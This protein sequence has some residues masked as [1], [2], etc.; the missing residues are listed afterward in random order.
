MKP[1]KFC[2]HEKSENFVRHCGTLT[3]CKNIHCDKPIHENMTT[4]SFILKKPDTTERTLQESH[5]LNVISPFEIWNELIALHQD[6][7]HLSCSDSSMKLKKLAWFYIS[8][9]LIL[10][11][12]VPNILAWFLSCSFCFSFNFLYSSLTS[13]LVTKLRKIWLPSD[14]YSNIR[15]H[16]INIFWWTTMCL[17][18]CFKERKLFHFA[19]V[20]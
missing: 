13:L 9:W 4:W 17:L 2:A 7:D 6:R 18:Q 10:E 14:G 12:M 16:Q 3:L 1:W 15:Q 11:N 5:Q 20:W 8:S 19:N